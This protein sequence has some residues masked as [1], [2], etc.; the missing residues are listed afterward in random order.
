MYI[1]FLI[2]GLLFNSSHAKSTDLNPTLTTLAESKEWQ[3]LLYYQPRTFKKGFKSEVA[4]PDFFIS[5]KGRLNPAEEMNESV[6]SFFDLDPKNLSPLNSSNIIINDEHPICKFPARFYFLSKKLKLNQMQK[7]AG[8]IKMNDF[9]QRLSGQSVSLIFSSYFINNPSSAFGHTFLKVNKSDDFELD[10]LNYGINYAATVDTVHPVLYPIKGLLGMFPGEFTAIPYYYKVR[11]YN[12]YESR[13][14]WEYQLNLNPEDI[15]F[16]NLHIWELGRAWAWYYFLDKNCSY[17]AIRVLEAIRPDLNL[18]QY[19]NGPFVV[20]IET[21][22]GLLLEKNLIKNIKYRPSL[23]EQLLSDINTLDSKDIK[24]METLVSDLSKNK[25]NALDL[26][27]EDPKFLDTTLLFYD[28]KNAKDVVANEEILL[29]KKQPLLQARSKMPSPQKKEFKLPKDNAPHE[30]HPPRRLSVSYKQQDLKNISERQGLGLRYKQGFHEILDSSR[31]FNPHMAINYLD[32]SVLAFNEK[33]L[34][35]GQTDEQS[36]ILDRFHL[37]SVEAFTPINRI[38]SSYSWRVKLGIDSEQFLKNWREKVAFISFETG[39]SKAF[40]DDQFLVYFLIG[41]TLEGNGRF[42]N[43][44]RLGLSPLIG[45]K[46]MMSKDTNL[47]LEAKPLWVADF[48]NKI[49]YI[50]QTSLQWQTY[51]PKINSSISFDASYLKSDDFE[52]FN[53]TAALSYYY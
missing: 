26:K 51:F 3:R 42:E 43:T 25:I 41:N 33:D 22:K 53:A 44:L 4:N 5:K 7:F 48:E 10:L 16:L 32:I 18:V 15:L 14:L 19:F 23:R 39:L 38:E 31:G 45:V 17:W 24:K 8:C 35:S 29:K 21:V 40:Y 11:E 46:Y 30:S 6:K 50:S 34:I 47:I 37:I 49:Q 27:N 12:D 52:G 1:V 13:D 2:F 28:Y 36:F 20:P 9:I